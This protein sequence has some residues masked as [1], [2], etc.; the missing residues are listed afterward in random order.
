MTATGPSLEDRVLIQELC[1]RYAWTLDTADTQG[2]VETF[3]EDG[4]FADL[5]ASDKEYRGRAAI[6]EYAYR[7]WHSDPFW[8]GRQH[9]IDMVLFEPDPQGRPEHWLMKSYM[10]AFDYQRHTHGVTFLVGY[11]L[12]IVAKVDGQW[13]FRDRRFSPWEGEVLSKFPGYED[14]V[15]QR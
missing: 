12:D 11:Y 15:K 7:R 6:F 2:Y 8:A 10:W 4:V 14:R 3:T 1:A 9:H 5:H 13:L